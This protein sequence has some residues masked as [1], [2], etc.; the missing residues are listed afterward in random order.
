MDFALHRPRP[1]MPFIEDVDVSDVEIKSEIKAEPD[2]RASPLFEPQQSNQTKRSLDDEIFVSDVKKPNVFTEYGPRAYGGGPLRE[3]VSGTKYVYWKHEAV[4]ELEVNSEHHQTAIKDFDFCINNVVL[5]A[6]VPYKDED[7]FINDIVDWYSQNAQVPAIPHTVFA[8]LG[9][10]G[11]GKTSTLN[12]LLGIPDLAVSDAAMESVT[13]T[14]QSFSHRAGQSTRFS[15]KVSFLNGRSIEILLRKCITDLVAYVDAMSDNDSDENGSAH[16][17]AESSRQVLDDL[18]SHQNGLKEL[19]DVEEFLEARELRVDGQISEPALQSLYQQIRERAFSEGIDLDA[20]EVKFTASDT[21]GLHGQAT[22]FSERGGFAPLVSSIRT[23]LHSPLL[24]MGIEI[25]DLP[26]Y[27]DTNDH[28]HKTSS[29]YLKECTK[30]IFVADLVRCMTT[31][32]VKKRLR[33]TI[34]LKG[35]ENVILILRGKEVRVE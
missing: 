26:G 1:A 30:V 2:G 34:K 31:P 21:G 12:N 4:P 16:D 28:L 25:A 22:I 35:A 11:S 5:P 29:E 32:E 6:L 19:E 7:K 10:A 23:Q 14:P 20:R 9:S 15:V 27:S 3:Y 24:A 8:L 33:E 18:F 13:Q 17:S